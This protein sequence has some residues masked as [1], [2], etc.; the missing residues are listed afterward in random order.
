MNECVETGY[1]FLIRRYSLAVCELY[2]QSF[3]TNKS[4]RQIVRSEH[5][6]KT[7]YPARRFSFEASWQ[8]QL[9][10]A[11]KY[12]G[13]NSEVLKAFFNKVDV[14]EL[15][16]FI[17]GHPLGTTQRRIWFLYEYLTGKRL[18][19][20]D[21]TGGSYV[22]LVD[23]SLQY[24]LPSSAGVR[25]RRYHVIN[26]LIGNS[27]FAPYVRKTEQTLMCSAD[28]LRA[29]SDRLL[30]N[31]SPD[32]L[33]RAVQYLY[34]KETKSSFAIERETPD[35]RRMDA[36]VAIL[37]GMSETPLT[38]DALIAAQNSV[39]DV[40]YRQDGWRTDQVYVGET[41]APGVEK[42]HY[43]APRPDAIGQLMDGFL[44][45]LEQ[46]MAACGSDPV[47]MAA[48]LGFA[49][50][51]LH[52]FDDGNGRVHR[53]LLHAILAQTGFAPHGLIFPVSAVM[54]KRQHEY[55]K[56]LET[57]SNRVMPL[58]DYEISDEGE[59]T[60][61]NDSRDLYRFIDYT[62]VVEY[63]QQVIVRTIQTEWKAEL[64]YLKR[65]DRIRSEMRKVVDLPEKGANQFIRFVQQNG[66][67]LSKAKRR[68]FAELTDAEVSRLEAIVGGEANE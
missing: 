21:G 50:V 22:P 8:G 45:C 43:V 7:Y 47:V 25:V 24:A 68:Y 41:L 40:R 35:Q 36:F 59:V 56:I 13:I 52:P 46:W 34:M 65:Y 5:K 12:E 3:V 26:N 1:L 64:D 67:R 29:E 37:R 57:F 53:F 18:D 58:L 48:V 42:V 19:I 61:R 6:V 32:L 23:D 44:Q 28:R 9:T 17:T 30:N 16:E 2:C 66:G 31:Y 20:Q 39:V 63:F 14:C 10:F 11:L 38:K 15:K 54:L 51:F 4:T 33:Y 60:V 49:F 55:D 27:G 62:P